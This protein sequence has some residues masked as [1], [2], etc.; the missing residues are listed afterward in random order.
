M[1]KATTASIFGF[2]LLFRCCWKSLHNVAFLTMASVDIAFASTPHNT[3]CLPYCVF[4]R[5]EMSNVAHTQ[6]AELGTTWF[7]WQT[8][9][10]HAAWTYIRWVAPSSGSS[11]SINWAWLSGE[12]K[13]LSLLS[14]VTNIAPNTHMYIT[15]KSAVSSEHDGSQTYT[16]SHLKMMFTLKKY[17]RSVNGGMT[18]W[19]CT[20]IV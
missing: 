4:D 14:A 8:I 7:Q 6:S 2:C 1:S 5:N 3:Y 13:T 16:K 20:G 10:A 11:I 18:H 15:H 17:R 9:G 12:R 19:L